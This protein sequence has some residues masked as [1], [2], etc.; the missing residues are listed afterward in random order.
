MPALPELQAHSK[1]LDQRYA[2]VALARSTPITFTA[3]KAA[4][5]SPS[6]A[7]GESMVFAGRRGKY[8]LLDFGSL[9]FIV[10]LMQGG[11]LKEE[12]QGKHPAKPRGGQARW[13]FADDR[14]LLLTEA[15]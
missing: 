14:A 8:L 4:A 9:T 15:G 6:E 12:P 10:H 5:P 11:R 3:L 7:Y 13:M 1:P 2:G